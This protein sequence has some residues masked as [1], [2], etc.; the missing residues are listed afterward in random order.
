MTIAGIK[1]VGYA[2]SE[3]GSLEYATTAITDNAMLPISLLSGTQLYTDEQVRKILIEFGVTYLPFIDET[4]VED[5][6]DEFIENN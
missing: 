6:V 1:P 5:I 2:T 3:L 4:G